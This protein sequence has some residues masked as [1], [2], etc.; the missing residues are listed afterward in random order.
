MSPLEPQLRLMMV[1]FGTLELELEWALRSGTV[2]GAGSVVV[3]VDGRASL[4]VVLV[5]VV[6][7]VLGA[8]GVD[9]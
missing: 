6:W 9:V 8:L 5:D 4:I 2:L 3:V 1:P 7:G